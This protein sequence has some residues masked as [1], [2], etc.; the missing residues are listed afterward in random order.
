MK[1]NAMLKAPVKA[2]PD[3]PA[4]GKRLKISNEFKHMALC[5]RGQ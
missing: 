4:P 3:G 2:G 1:K 5:G